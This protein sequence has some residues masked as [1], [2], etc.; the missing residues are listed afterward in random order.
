[1]IG[2]S[3]WPRLL[4]I[5]CVCAEVVITGWYLGT[6]AHAWVCVGAVVLGSLYVGREWQW[7]STRKRE[8]RRD[9]A[10]ERFFAEQAADETDPPVTPAPKERQP[11]G[12]E[13]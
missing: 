12:S 10:W 13:E 8:D 2:A 5:G 6:I 7:L 1:M 4:I 11:K 9:A 3:M